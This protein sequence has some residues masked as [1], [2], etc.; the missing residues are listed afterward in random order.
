MLPA[1]TNQQSKLYSKRDSLFLALLSMGALV[2][3]LIGIWHFSY[4]GQDFVVHRSL[5]LSFPGGYTYNLTSPPGLYWLGSV[6]HNH[7][8]SSHYLE[9]LA[10]VFLVLNIGALRIFYGFLWQSMVRWQLRY[11]AAAF[12]T[13]VPFRVIH[14]LVIASDALTVP[15]FALAILFSLHLYENPRRPMSWIGLAVTLLAGILCKYSVV[16]LL[17][18]VVLLMSISIGRRL[19]AGERLLWIAI[20]VATVSLPAAGFWLQMHESSK[21]GGPI[22]NAQWLPRGSPS[23]M[24]WSDML[25]LQKSDVGLLS[26][27]RYIQGDL[28]G[29]RKFSYAGL[30]HVA[31][32]SDIF[33]FFQPPP[34]DMVFDW[35]ERPDDPAALRLDTAT[36]LRDYGRS[37]QS[38][39]LQVG[40]VRLCLVFSALAIL[41]TLFCSV[42]S[43]QSLLFRR[44]LLPNATVVMT[45][46]AVGYY[47]PVFIGL[48][49]INDPY[50]AG[51]WLPRLV[52]PALVIFFGLGF[53]AVD[54]LC[55]RGPGRSPVL[56]LS[57]DAFAAYTLAACL[58]F[59]GFL[60]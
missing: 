32:V 41:G 59:V 47:L 7:V 13:F 5:I 29:Y 24:R 23:V 16:G 38:Q 19:D 53:V 18:P 17:P 58:L 56:N 35:A 15:V 60:T 21:V 3:G 1:P 25:T 54:F 22:T 8:T 46:M 31:S 45:A 48:H 27:P 44:P 51:F 36:S 4:A 6:I 14:T 50:T 9:C 26:A 12:I 42:L 33:D 40:S 37:A 52:M 34:K 49:R 30:L 57:L 28:Y 10:L 11:S 55:R 39:D 43:W 2:L 20:A